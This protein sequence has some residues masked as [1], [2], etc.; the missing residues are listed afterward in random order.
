MVSGPPPPQNYFQLPILA[1]PGVRR[2]GQITSGTFPFFAAVYLPA[3][4]RPVALTA[5][6]LEVVVLAVVGA[7]AIVDVVD[8]KGCRCGVMVSAVG[9]GV[10]VAVEY[11]A[12]GCGGYVLGGVCPGHRSP[13]FVPCSGREPAACISGG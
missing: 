3:G 9:A 7:A 8:F 5:E 4:F 13:F 10:C 12:S 6:Y 1:Q 2:P 11:A